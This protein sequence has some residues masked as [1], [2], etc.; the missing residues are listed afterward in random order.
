M[1]RLKPLLV[2]AGSW[3]HNPLCFP[4]EIN[5]QASKKNSGAT[6][7]TGI[8]RKK[9]KCALMLFSSLLFSC[10]CLACAQCSKQWLG[11]AL[12]QEQGVPW[13]RARSLPGWQDRTELHLLCPSHGYL[14]REPE[15]RE[16]CCQKA[17]HPKCWDGQQMND[18]LKSRSPGFTAELWWQKVTAF[19]SGKQEWERFK[20]PKQERV[21]RQAR[22]MSATLK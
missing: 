5:S 17:A 12:C 6:D 8:R 10:Y 2:A 14:G 9:K 18:A 15:S 7:M 22:G 11:W 21:R 3:S 4:L 1:Q 20:S 16:K 19:R 13:I